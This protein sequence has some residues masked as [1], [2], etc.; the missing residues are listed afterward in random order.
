MR[1]GLGPGGIPQHLVMNQIFGAL[2]QR[3]ADRRGTA[4]AN[5]LAEIL[6]VHRGLEEGRLGDYV[7]NQQGERYPLAEKEE[8][9][10]T[11][12]ALDQI[13]TALIENSNAHRPVPAT[14]QV[15]DRLDH[16]VL[17]EG[18]KWQVRNQPCNILT[19]VPSPPSRTSLCNLQGPVFVENRRPR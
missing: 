10:T 5:P 8:K 15:V 6:G 11:C 2:A 18:C 14:E 16:Q 13:M 19:L 1:D 12:V 9:S 7:L 17:E 3:H 4:A